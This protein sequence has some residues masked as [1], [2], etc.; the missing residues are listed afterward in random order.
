MSEFTATFANR[1]VLNYR[2]TS[3][4]QIDA[5]NGCLTIVDSNRK[6]TT[7]S[8]AAWM[9]VEETDTFVVPTEE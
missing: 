2:G 6:R 1:V 3:R 7:Y 8:P 5:T 4:F 9:S